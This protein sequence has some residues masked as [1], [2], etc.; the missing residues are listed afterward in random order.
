MVLTRVGQTWS[1]SFM[2]MISYVAIGGFMSLSLLLPA[3]FVAPD[4]EQIL[5]AVAMSL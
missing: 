2:T 4:T 1:D 5:M 3:I